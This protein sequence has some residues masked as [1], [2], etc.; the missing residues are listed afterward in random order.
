MDLW[1]GRIIPHVQTAARQPVSRPMRSS[2]HF[3]G[4]SSRRPDWHAADHPSLALFP[5]RAYDSETDDAR[6]DS[7]EQTP[8]GGPAMTGPDAADRAR[9]ARA[10]PLRVRVNAAAAARGRGRGIGRA[11]P[12]LARGGGRSGPL[13]GDRPPADPGR[14]RPQRLRRRPRGSGGR[15]GGG[16]RPRGRVGRRHRRAHSRLSQR[17]PG[18]ELRRLQAAHRS[19]HGRRDPALALRGTGGMGDHEGDRG[20]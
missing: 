7:M 20:G 10:P 16:G 2:R 13:A 8:A 4:I 19:G 5:A 11:A 17:L 18:D 14:L 6:G 12:S 3:A 9:R 15:P 1:H